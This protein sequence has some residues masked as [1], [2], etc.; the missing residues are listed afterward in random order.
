MND[1]KWPA[2][3][4]PLFWWSGRLNWIWIYWYP[5]SMVNHGTFSSER[6]LVPSPFDHFKQN[7]QEW[8]AFLIKTSFQKRSTCKPSCPPMIPLAFLRQKR[9]WLA[10]T[11]VSLSFWL[12]GVSLVA[13]KCP[14]TSA[15]QQVAE[16]VK[17]PMDRMWMW[18]VRISYVSEVVN[19][20]YGC[21]QKSGSFV[22]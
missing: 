4:V 19:G 6:S 21:F 1:K 10:G 18:K 16:S 5:L 20:Y 22:S 3:V 13:I 15:G 7:F 12:G 8:V 17:P 14:K 11:A 2:Q 9:A